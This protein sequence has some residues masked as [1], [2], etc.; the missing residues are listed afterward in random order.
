[1]NE[2]NVIIVHMSYASVTAHNAPP[3]DQ[4]PHPDTALLNTTP[5]TAAAVANDTSK[6]NLV[7]PDFREN[8][9]TTTS[10]AEILPQNVVTLKTT[11]DDR[12][13][14]NHLDKHTGMN[15]HEVKRPVQEGKAR[16]NGLCGSVVEYLVRPG[17]AG[18]LLGLGVS[19]SSKDTMY[20]KLTLTDLQ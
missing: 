14:T 4:Q 3:L 1:L 11:R 2:D 17:V 15:H 20:I 5:P 6:V 9:Q 12:Q 18:G 10:E 19:L 8:P 7:P 16:T 13:E